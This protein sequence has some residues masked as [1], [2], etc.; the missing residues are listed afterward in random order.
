MVPCLPRIGF[1]CTWLS[2]VAR[3]L[4]LSASAMIGIPGYARAAVE[5]IS[6]NF[7]HGA[8][9]QALAVSPCMDCLGAGCQECYCLLAATHISCLRLAAGEPLQGDA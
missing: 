3:V 1:C 5:A 6:L 2:N 9:L 8:V 4:I 7:M